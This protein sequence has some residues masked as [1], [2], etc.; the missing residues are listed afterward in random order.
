MPFEVE[1]GVPIPTQRMMAGMIKYPLGQMEVGDS[2]LFDV[3][4]RK[5]VTNA[6][7]SYGKTSGR[8]F[9]VR[10]INTIEGRCW[11]IE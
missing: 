8:R 10:T 9:T 3:G 4:D 2:F 7:A 11:R 5:R 1:K 6:A